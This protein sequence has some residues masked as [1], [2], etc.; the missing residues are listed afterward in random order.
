MISGAGVASGLAFLALAGA[1]AAPAAAPALSLS[2]D[3]AV[4][5]TPRTTGSRTVRATPGWASTNW[6]GYAVTTTAK[7][8]GVT[9]AWAV[10]TVARTSGPTYSAAWIGIDGFN[11]SSLI[12]TGTEEDYYSGAAHY[13]VW[14]TTSAQGFAEQTISEPVSP[15]DRMAAEITAA[16]GGT[17]TITL[18]DTSSAHPWTFTKSLA[19]SGPGE[20]AEWIIEAPTVGNRQSAI[21]DYSTTE[22]DPGFL[23]SLT[24]TVQVN[25]GAF[26]S[27]GLV[28]SDGGELVAESGRRGYTVTSIPSTPDTATHSA[29]NMAYG[30]TA[31]PAPTS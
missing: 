10:P 8:T 17:W 25:G 7:F 13:A 6:S 24:G 22:F 9:G 2:P 31:P 5:S 27:P 1:G 23:T 4:S 29:F 18:S 14:W 20:S 28:A 19:Y 12:Q 21:A 26:T 16:A 15:G 11:N 3:H 30:A